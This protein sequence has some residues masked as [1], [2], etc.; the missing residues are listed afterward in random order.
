M[1]QRITIKESDKFW[2]IRNWIH[3]EE[4]YMFSGSCYVVRQ[5]TFVTSYWVSKGNVNK[6]FFFISLE[7]QVD[8]LD[9]EIV[10]LDQFLTCAN[11][12]WLSNAS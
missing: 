4:V 7:S 8:F 9:E 11:F 1:I 10:T 2:W 6:V 3:L 12:N 5:I